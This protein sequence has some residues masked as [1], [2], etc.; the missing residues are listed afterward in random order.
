KGTGNRPLTELGSPA[1]KVLLVLDQFEQWLHAK[2]SEQ[3]TELVQALRQCDGVHVHCLILVRDD[4]G[5]AATRFMNDLEIRIVEGQNFATVDLFDPGH[6][7]KVLAE[8]GRAFGQ[9]PAS[10]AAPAPEQERFLDQAVAG[11]AQDGK[12]IS[13][14]LAVFAE[15]VKGKPW[16][17]ATLRQVGGAEGVGV[18]FLEETF[19]AATAPPPHR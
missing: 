16:T 11:L 5:M 14:R 7:R 17:P 9:L 12:V 1:G 3:L 8:F 4:F 13:V 19:S 10:P 2:R 18:T 6:A 15:M